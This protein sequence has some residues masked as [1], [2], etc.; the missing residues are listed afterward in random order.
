MAGVLA[1][2]GGMRPRRHAVGTRRGVVLGPRLFCEG[3][4]PCAL[5]RVPA[6]RRRGAAADARAVRR[7]SAPPGPARGVRPRGGP[8]LRALPQ[9]R[10]PLPAV[11]R[12]PDPDVLSAHAA[13]GLRPGAGGRGPGGGAA[14]CGGRG[15]APPA[16]VA[17]AA[18]VL[19]MGRRGCARCLR[20]QLRDDDGGPA[21]RDDRLAELVRLV[22]GARPRGAGPHGAGP[23]PAHRRRTGAGPL[24]ACSS[25]SSACSICTTRWRRACRW[26]RCG[27]T[28]RSS[29]RSR[30]SS[31]P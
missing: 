20:R 17:V 28:S 6:G 21:R 9:L 3:R 10:H 15:G 12:I 7:S 23:R 18:V 29:S 8:Q 4:S 22:A 30:C 13:A 5:A 25:A 31:A 19:G 16:G 27:G 1:L 2:A 24:W 26:N 11:C 14:G